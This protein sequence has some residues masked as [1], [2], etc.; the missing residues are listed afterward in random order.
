MARSSAAHPIIVGPVGDGTS[1]AGLDR[2]SEEGFV[3]GLEGIVFGLLIFVAGTLLVAWAWAVVDTKLVMVRAAEQAARYFAV[4]S[5]PSQ[6]WSEAS[7]AAEAV[8]ASSGRNPA[9]ARV[10]LSSGAFRRCERVR[11]TVAYPAPL[12]DVP[13]VGP[14]GGGG[15]V[16]GQGSEL[17]LPYR[18]GPAGQA[19]C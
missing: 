16:Q 17:V 8:V 3:G 10:R 9:L 12:L 2:R 4:A 5:T 19:Q 7:S 6:A 13:F 11:I 15:W 1:P 18:S 14:V